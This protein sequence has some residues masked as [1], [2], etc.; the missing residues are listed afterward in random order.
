MLTRNRMLVVAV[1]VAAVGMLSAS[2]EVTSI[3]ATTSANVYKTISGDPDASDQDSTAYPDPEGTLPIQSLANLSA[4]DD[5]AGAVVAAQVADPATAS[6]TNP[7][8]FALM[9][10]LDTLSPTVSFTADATGEEVRTITYSPDDF[11]GAASG[12]SVDLA[13][14]FFLDA[15]LAVFAASNATDLTDVSWTLRVT[16]VQETPG[17]A[18]VTVFDGSLLISGGTGGQFNTSYT[19]AI[20]AAAVLSADLSFVDDELGV[21]QVFTIANQTLEYD[22]SVVIGQPF[23]LRAT[24]VLE[25]TGGSDGV[26]I[27]G[28]V[29]PELDELTLAIAAARGEQAASKLTA[30]MLQERETPSGKPV[31][32][33]A[34]VS[35][36]PCG[37]LSA[38]GLLGV[39]SIVGFIGLAGLCCVGSRRHSKM[40]L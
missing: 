17:Q 18:P 28:I 1:T 36:C 10:V 19:G 30:A 9:I 34:T 38:C 23:A 39:E 31:F 21:F 2:A 37:F 20:P 4:A 32:A 7:E 25:A 40:R 8:D 14:R 3:T 5:E 15:A 26:G 33:A 11:S 27:A 24:V 16:I 35:P 12:D 22:Y 29:G 13:G 6:G